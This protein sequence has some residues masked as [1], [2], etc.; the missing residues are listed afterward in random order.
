[1]KL[2]KILDKF[3]FALIIALGFLGSILLGLKTYSL[4]ADINSPVDD[5]T[6]QAVFLSNN[7]V[8]FGHLKNI[9]SDYPILTNVY[10]VKLE[11]DSSQAGNSP[12]SP[13]GKL[14]KLGDNEPHGPRDEMIINKDHILF[15]ENLNTD[16]QIVKLIEQMRSGR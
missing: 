15:W 5:S 7:Q 11:G 3:P 8:Y 16:S 9:N 1:M 4:V 10:Y 13:T 2:S 12:N 6:Y 14:V